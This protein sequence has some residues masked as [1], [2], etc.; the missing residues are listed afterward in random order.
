[1]KKVNLVL[2]FFILLL[3]FGCESHNDAKHEPSISGP[4]KDNQTWFDDESQVVTSAT[5][6]LSSLPSSSLCAPYDNTTAPLRPCTLDDVLH[7]TDAFDD[8]SPELSVIFSATEF[9]NVNELTNAL[10]KQKGKSTRKAP[11]K[12]YKV[13]LDS[14]TVLYKKQRRLQY[15]KHS[16]D[17]TR[18]RN[19]LSF[20]LFQ[21]IPNFNSLKTEFVQLTID[22][23]DKGLYTKI[24]SYDKEYLINR[25]YNED[26][27]LYKAQYF[28]FY[29][30]PSLVLNDDGN[31]IDKVSFEKIIEPQRGKSQT[32]LLA[33]LNAI[34][35]EE[36]DIDSIITQYFNRDNYLTWLAVNIIMG[37]VDTTS[38]N[39]FLLNPIYSDTFYFLPWDYDD[40]WGWDAQLNQFNTPYYADWELGIARYWDSPLHRRFLSKKVN[41]DALDNMIDTIRN[42]YLTDARV[43]E[44]VATYKPLVQPFIVNAPDKDYLPYGENGAPSEA[45][46]NNE[47]DVLVNALSKNITN[48]NAEKGKPMPFWQS[49]EYKNGVMRLIW[50]SSID[51]EGEIVTYSVKLGNDKNLTAPLLVDEIDLE[52][53]DEKISVTSYGEVSYK[54]TPTVPFVSGQKLYL[55]VTSKD[56]SNN[57]QIAF[58]KVEDENI[59]NQFYHGLY[60]IV[61]P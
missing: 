21:D 39:F 54:Y 40:A 2:F 48:Y 25:G 44:K 1:L 45:D 20:D 38:Q 55:K 49:F 8:Y 60:E 61:I 11:Q 41:R 30:H 9:L 59:D 42:N 23:E 4:I 6:T 28:W 10:L 26:D 19:K 24:E 13:K 37:N 58:D 32:K 14:K 15:N 22:G 50:D 16:F 35:D 43:N 47:C 53:S 27:N 33:M 5:V 3:F 36:R 17:L 18:I 57:T 52:I 12:S 34:E 7:D 51:L 31:P 56:T 46:W 29:K